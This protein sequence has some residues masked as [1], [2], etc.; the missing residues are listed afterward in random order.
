MKTFRKCLAVR[1]LQA[2]LIVMERFWKN[3]EG[4]DWLS[5]QTKP[6]KSE[7]YEIQ[8]RHEVMEQERYQL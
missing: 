3:Q 1:A 7:S 5:L 2:E 6:F 8:M 4:E